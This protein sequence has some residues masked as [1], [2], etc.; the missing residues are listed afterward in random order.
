M[1]PK[2]VNILPPSA[3]YLGDH[4]AVGIFLQETVGLIMRGT[5]FPCGL[6]QLGGPQR[7]WPRGSPCVREL[8]GRPEALC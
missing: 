6:A 8:G 1:G 5:H 7:S 4:E 2:P 3:P